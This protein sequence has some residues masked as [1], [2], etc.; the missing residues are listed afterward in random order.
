GE[1]LR[2]TIETSLTDASVVAEILGRIAFENDHRY[3]PD[4]ARVIEL[5]VRDSEGRNATALRTVSVTPV[6]FAPRI[7][8]SPILSTTADR[9]ISFPVSVLK[10]SATDPDGDALA[11]TLPSPNGDNGG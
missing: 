7:V 6:N 3:P 1:P 4:Q 2:L 5:S 8:A 9:D 10:S 11:V